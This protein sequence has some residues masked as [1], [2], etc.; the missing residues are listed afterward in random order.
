MPA[1]RKVK[2]QTE[3]ER[4]QAKIE[5]NKRYYSKHSEILKEKRTTKKEQP[6]TTK[7]NIFDDSD[8]EVKE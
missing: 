4:K 6:V 5:Y 7:E 3:E 8:D 1:G 2:Y